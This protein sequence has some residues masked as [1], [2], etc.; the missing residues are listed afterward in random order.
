MSSRKRKTPVMKRTHLDSGDE[1]GTPDG[2]DNE[3]QPTT[4][5]VG[6]C[7]CVCACTVPILHVFV[8]NDVHVHTCIPWGKLTVYT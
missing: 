1:D 6:E 8:D 7:V 5:S 2:S 4:V 3:Y